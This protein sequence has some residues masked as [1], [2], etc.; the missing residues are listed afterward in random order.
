MTAGAGNTA[1]IARALDGQ[2]RVGSTRR[3]IACIAKRGG[4]PTHQTGLSVRLAAFAV[5]FEQQLVAE[6]LHG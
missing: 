6:R 5:P 3:G 1:P 4:R 2:A